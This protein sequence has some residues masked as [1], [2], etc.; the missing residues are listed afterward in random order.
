MTDQK[1]NCI[2][3][4]CTPSGSGA[5]ALLRVSG[6]DS[7]KCIAQCSLLSSKKLLQDVVTHTIHHGWVVN[8]NQEM[9]DEVMFIVMHAPR[10]FTGETTVEITCHNNQFIIEAIIQRVI[11]CGA[12]LAHNGEFSR[13]AVLNNKMDIIQAEAINDLINAHS[14][15][16]LKRSLAQ[17]QGS[18]SSWLQLIEKDLLKALALCE[19]SF[20][21][22][23]EDMDFSEQLKNSLTTVLTTLKNL[24]NN[25]QQNHMREGIKI[26]IIGSVN[27]GKSSLFNA[28]LGKN[29]A[30]VTPIAGTTRDVIEASFYHDGLYWT[31]IDTAGL[32]Q[33]DDVI[34]QEGIKKSHQ[35]AAVADLVLLV[36]DNS[37]T[38]TPEEFIVYQ[39]LIEKFQDKIIKVKNKTDIVLEKENY[40]LN[41]KFIKLFSDALLVSN[42]NQD[43]I[44]ALKDSIALFVN[45]L[46]NNNNCPFL[47]NKRQL[48]LL[49]T[50]QLELESLLC[51]FEKTLEYELVAHHLK[52][53]LE[54]LSELTGRSINEKMLDTI[55]KEF[56][57]GK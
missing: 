37:R 33:T 34:E 29:R 1:L 47:L 28:L 49:S 35:E 43:A 17:V 39:N 15:E 48:T 11:A 56:C 55:F 57:V 23:E 7:I 24:T 8:N 13:Q 40:N 46:I 50:C 20:E 30:I 4:Q 2:V 45:K 54:T 44:N 18:L 51:L 53:I 21:F 3:A 10:T 5:I 32:R 38:I 14:Q 22:L 52:N 31:F 41:D 25:A 19:A 27:A 26:A 36:V 42:K 9:L 16:A 6:P 12:R